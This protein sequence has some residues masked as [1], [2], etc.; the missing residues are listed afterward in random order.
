MNNNFSTFKKKLKKEKMLL[1]LKKELANLEFLTKH[2][3]LVEIQN[4]ITKKLK[5]AGKSL[6]YIMPYFL[7]VTILTGVCKL[8]TSSFPFYLDEVKQYKKTIKEFDYTGL[9]KIDTTYEKI[10]INSSI[11]TYTTAWKKEA[12]SFTRQTKIYNL[13]ILTGENILS[14]LQNPPINLEDILGEPIKVSQEYSPFLSPKE[15][16]LKPIL[17]AYLYEENLNDYIL[18]EEDKN[19]NLLISVLYTILT[20]GATSATYFFLSAKPDYNFPADIQEIMKDNGL[21]KK[22][23]Y[24]ILELKKKNY[25]RL[26]GELDEHVQR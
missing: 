2:Y 11:L 26:V 14:L 12:A 4:E 3:Q 15:R 9:T 10:N 8:S 1:Q 24:Q 19:Y 25:N 7:V 16:N 21:N 18:L 13:N 5:I 22:D 20:L 17:K 6:E 23:L